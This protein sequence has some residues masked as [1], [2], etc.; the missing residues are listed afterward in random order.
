M[1]TTCLV[2]GVRSTG[3]QGSANKV[4][5]DKALLAY[6]DKF[7]GGIKGDLDPVTIRGGVFIMRYIE[8][9]VKMSFYAWT[10]I[11]S[12]VIL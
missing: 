3:V 6:E 4:D 2:I 9:V 5:M 8:L 12:F 10:P 1:M 7:W 11:N